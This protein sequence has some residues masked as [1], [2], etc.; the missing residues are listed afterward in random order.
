MWHGDWTWWEWFW[1]TLSMI[2]FWAIVI[3]AAV[4]I[5]RRGDGGAAVDSNADAVLADRFARG[6]IDEEEY[7]RRHAALE[8]VTKAGR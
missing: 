4:G 3:W 8:D 6:E 5:L 1:M 2:A 7:R